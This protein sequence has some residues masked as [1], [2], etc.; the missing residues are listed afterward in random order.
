MRWDQSV[1]NSEIWVQPYSTYLDADALLIF[2]GGALRS[3]RALAG[4][5]SGKWY[6]EVTQVSSTASDYNL[7]GI[8]PVGQ[9]ITAS[10]EYVGQT[11]TS[12]G[13]YQQTGQ[14]YSNNTLASYGASWT[15]GDIIGVAMDL[16]NGK[17][18]FAKNNT[19]QASGNPASG[20]NPA[21]SSISGTYHVAATM[22]VGWTATAGDT[23]RLGFSSGECTY[24]PPSGFEHFLRPGSVTLTLRDEA[25]A[26]INSTSFSWAFFEGDTPDVLTTPTATGT[27]STNGSGVLVI[28]IP[29]TSL[30][31]GGTGSLLLSTTGG[32][33]GV[34]CRSWYMPVTVTV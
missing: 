32:T 34:Q 8:V 23:V 21:Y 31:N 14:K 2:G 11:S 17:V 3:V 18:F 22:Y 13:Y 19:W 25:G 33:A 28:S 1:K 7:I 30:E 16:T 6:A 9:S 24:S 10:G 15:T 26:T 5:S 20:A 27:T 4:R 29:L 12:Y